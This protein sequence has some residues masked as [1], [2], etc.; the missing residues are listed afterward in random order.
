MDITQLPIKEVQH[1]HSGQYH[2]YGD[3]WS[4]WNITLEDNAE[5]EREDILNYC[6]SELSKRKVQ[7]HKEWS[8]HYGD[9]SSYFSG[10]YELTKT[11]NV[12][13]YKVCSPYTD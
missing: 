4:V 7:S 5:V 3:S 1:V 2:A 12:Y 13:T 8:E 11:G 6:F 10:Y 9:A